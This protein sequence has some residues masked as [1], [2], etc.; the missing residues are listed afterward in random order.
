M[1]P[2]VGVPRKNCPENMQQIYWRTQ[3]WRDASVD[4]DFCQRIL[5]D[6]ENY[7]HQEFKLI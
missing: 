6:F 1:L 4:R 2:S 3:I 7:L 5:L